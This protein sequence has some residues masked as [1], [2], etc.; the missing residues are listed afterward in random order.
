MN[1]CAQ[2]GRLLLA[3]ALTL[4][5]VNSAQARRMIPD[6]NLAYPVLIILQNKAGT[7]L[8]FGWVSILAQPTPSIW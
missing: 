3:I 7:T 4:V 2:I 8:G 1:R 5:F 6:D